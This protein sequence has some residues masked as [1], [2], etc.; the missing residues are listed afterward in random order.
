MKQYIQ[1]FTLILLLSLITST[2][3]AQVVR[4]VNNRVGINTTNPAYPLHVAGDMY[5]NWIRTAGQRGLYSQSY[6]IYLRALS[7]NYWSSRSDRGIVIRNRAGTNKGYLYHDNGSS[8]G[9]LDADGAWS[10]RIVRDSWMRWSSNNIIRMTLQSNGRLDLP[11]GSDASGTANTGALQI[12]GALRLDGNE[13]ITNTNNTLYLQHFN[14]GDLRVDNTTLFVDA[15]ANRIH[16]PFIYDANNTGYYLDPSSI[17]RMNYVLPR[18][19]N[20]GYCGTS[21]STWNYGYFRYLYRQYEYTLS[22]RRAKENIREIDNALDKVLAL[23]GKLYNYKASVEEG[24]DITNFDRE[25]KITPVQTNVQTDKELTFVDHKLEEGQEVQDEIVADFTV[26]EEV[27]TEVEDTELS[28]RDQNEISKM[29]ASARSSQQKDSYGF[30]AQEVEKII[31]EAVTY[32]AENDVYSMSYQSIVPLL[33]EGMKEQQKHISAQKEILEAQ[34][35]Q[36]DE[37]KKLIEQK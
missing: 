6:G 23:D 4:V 20:V 30:I 11:N 14:N 16:T 12:Q 9:L 26:T 32:D 27:V 25:E 24:N 17:S 19:D 7:A 37:L 22:D 1:Y 18:V 28:S 3:D 21:A 10:M 8:F 33:V 29:T 31:P 13:I 36:I 2:L 35:K 34:Q 15:S 5:G